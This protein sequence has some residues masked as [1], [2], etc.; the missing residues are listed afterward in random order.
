[1]SQELLKLVVDSKNTYLEEQNV[2]HLSPEKMHLIK[3]LDN[4]RF[5][6]CE[7]HN[8][9]ID[10]I[11]PLFLAQLMNKLVVDSEVKVFISQPITVMQD[12]DAKQVEA[13]AKLA[14]YIHIETYDC[15][16]EEKDYKYSSKSIS[17][18]KP[19]KEGVKSELY[20]QEKKVVKK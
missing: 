2:F 3:C 13:N 12:Y 11:T 18:L 9:V 8:T 20:V 14:G 19:N 17:F 7:I 10:R 6:S 1:M 15:E 16:I 5:N 4:E